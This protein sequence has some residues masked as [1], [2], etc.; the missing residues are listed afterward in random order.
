MNVEFP[1]IDP[2]GHVRIRVR[3]RNITCSRGSSRSRH[4]NKSL[5]NLRKHV[6][7]L[8]QLPLSAPKSSLK[9]GIVPRRR[10]GR[11]LKTPRRR[12][13]NRSKRPNRRAGGPSVSPRA[14]PSRHRIRFQSLSRRLLRRGLRDLPKKS[15]SI[16]SKGRRNPNCRSART[17][18]RSWPSS[19]LSKSKS[20]KIVNINPRRGR[21][22]T[23]P[24]DTFNVNSQTSIPRK[25]ICAID[26]GAEEA[27]TIH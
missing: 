5:H 1:T 24:N 20:L 25:A 26:G 12:S 16:R 8:Q 15:L 2:R 10:G 7:H 22:R 3:I 14:L 6:L 9:S 23:L 17:Y 27:L 21:G 19:L 11:W 13:E 18:L 4:R